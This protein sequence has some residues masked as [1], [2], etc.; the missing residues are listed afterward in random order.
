MQSNLKR[1]T[2]LLTVFVV[3]GLSECR[4]ETVELMQIFSESF[5]SGLGP[6]LVTMKPFDPQRGTLKEVEVTIVG[7]MTGSS[8][9]PDPLVVKQ[10][11]RSVFGDIKFGSPAEFHFPA[12]V[13]VL[14][15]IIPVPFGRA[16]TYKVRFTETTDMFGGFAIPDF[17]GVD[18]PPLF[19]KGLVSDF[20]ED[21]FNP[22]LSMIL[23]HS[24]SSGAA[25]GFVVQGSVTIQ[26][27]Y[28]AD[29]ISMPVTKLVD[30]QEAACEA[31]ADPRAPESGG[32]GNPDLQRPCVYPNG[33]YLDNSD[34]RF[35][36]NVYNTT[37]AGL[38]GTFLLDDSLPF[39][40]P[41]PRVPPQFHPFI[42]PGTELTF[43]E[44]PDVISSPPYQLTSA[45]ITHLV[46]DTEV[47]TIQERIYFHQGYACFNTVIPGAQTGVTEVRTALNNSQVC[48]YSQGYYG[49]R[50]SRAGGNLYEHFG[51]VYDNASTWL[52]VGDRTPLGLLETADDADGWGML[53][54]SAAAVKDYLPAG[55]APNSLNEDHT[56]PIR[57]T[58]PAD[59]NSSGVFGG[60]V[61]A[62]QLN[63]DL[64]NANVFGGIGNYLVY[65]GEGQCGNGKTVSEILTEANQ[66]LAGSAASCT[67]SELNALVTRLNESFANCVSSDASLFE[68]P[69]ASD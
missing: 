28:V 53:F 67:I 26:Y 22:D 50:G 41:G 62:L 23:D 8:T 60:Q 1:L 5:T 19:V 34:P 32:T 35:D 12:A 33:L 61:L 16:F 21:D 4:A 9:L 54:T 36:I 15:V 49:N 17:S 69:T 40:V 68:A 64:G 45:T 46:G 6:A 55:G 57:G 2:V 3:V 38:P 27:T 13:N 7:G 58:R 11:F 37:E 30:G 20:V 59:R 31:G 42:A 65:P 63:V 18:V 51:E 47:A 39:P 14:G 66:A 24:T 52:Q 25:A 10:S 29:L 44:A 56:N 43:C 48:T